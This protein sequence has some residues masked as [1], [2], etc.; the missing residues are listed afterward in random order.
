M[1]HG[2]HLSL[3]LLVTTLAGAFACNPQVAAAHEPIS[4]RPYDYNYNN[5]YVSQDISVELVSPS[6][7]LSSYW[8]QGVSYVEGRMGERYNIRLTN[9]S[10]ARVEAVVTVDGRDVLSGDLGD[11]RKHRGYVLEPYASVTIEGFRQSLDYVAAFRFADVRSSYSSLRGTPQHVGVIGVATFKE[12]Q[13][14][15]WGRAPQ[16]VAPPPRPYYEPYGGAR[17]ERS[18]GDAPAAESAPQASAPA[19]KSSA[20]ESVGYGGSASFAP[21]PRGNRLGTEY[22]ETTYSSVREV[23]FKRDNPRRPDGVIT[24]YYDSREGLRAR[25]VPVDPPPPPV[26]YNPPYNP[27]PFPDSRFAPPP[28]RRY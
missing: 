22:G 8:H 19:R 7:G 13:A 18:R 16:P 5:N 20:D 2:N 10:G 9:H 4:E 15:R 11:Y 1:R 17:D 24:M 26:Y 14:R 3:G 27:Q 23:S 25:G 12:Q 28:P 6:G 21:P